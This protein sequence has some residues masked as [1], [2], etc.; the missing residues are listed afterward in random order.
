MSDPT[1]GVPEYKPV[2]ARLAWL[3]PALVALA[4]LVSQAYMLAGNHFAAI[5]QTRFL[6]YCLLGAFAI[7]MWSRPARSEIIWTLALA[8]IYTLSFVLF[9][10]QFQADWRGCVACGSF[11]GFASLSI[12]A[13]RV[14]CLRGDRQLESC[15][16]LIAG[17]VFG[18]S[19]VAIGFVLKLTA[20]LQPRTYDLYLYAADMGFGWPLC[21]WIGHF[22]R[23][24]V[25]L[26]K[27]CGVGYECLPLLISLLYACERSGKQSLMPIRVLPAFLGGGAAV[28][29]LYNVLPAA[30]PTFVF[31]AAFP[32]HL[33][34]LASLAIQPIALAN[35]PRNAVPSMHLA[36]AVLIYWSCRRLPL[37]VRIGSAL[38]IVL[39]LLAT[40]GFGEHYVMDLVAGLPYAL[41]VQAVCAPRVL[42]Q[43]TSVWWTFATGLGLTVAWIFALRFGVALFHSVAFTW[44]ASVSTVALCWI[45]QRRFVRTR[46]LDT[47]AIG[48]GVV[49]PGLVDAA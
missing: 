30:G 48:S 1:A 17:T 43:H 44:M 24:Q 28:Y 36:C 11:L 38:Y 25:V 46:L 9:T 4:I 34:A 32:D 3:G 15:N 20:I 19:A 49:Q 47:N 18:Y 40:I 16:T 14:F 10:Y 2:S 22:L 39:T 31:D 8:T 33:P 35:A 29:V 12:L 42:R 13:V 5:L 21:A 26:S 23:G 27:I 7:H 41:A 45:M 6:P 37:W